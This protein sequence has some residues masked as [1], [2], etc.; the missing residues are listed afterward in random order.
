[1]SHLFSVVSWL[2]IC[3]EVAVDRIPRISIQPYPSLP[4]SLV[5]F[6]PYTEFPSSNPW[7]L[8]EISTRL[9][10]AKALLVLI[11]LS[12]SESNMQSSEMGQS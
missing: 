5:F 1:M 9:K 2:E 6:R 3:V 12:S 10:C 11:P 4:F 8:F 7:Q